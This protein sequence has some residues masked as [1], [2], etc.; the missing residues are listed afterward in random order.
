MAAAVMTGIY[1]FQ[2]PVQFKCTSNDCTFPDFT[3]LG[4]CSECEDVTA[5]TVETCNS[6]KFQHYYDY[7]LPNGA[8]LSGTAQLDANTG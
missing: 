2:N 4:V 1:G 5:S 6:T 7:Q 8:M 3:S